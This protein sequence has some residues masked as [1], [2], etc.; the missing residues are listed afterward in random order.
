MEKES[1]DFKVHIQQNRLTYLPFDND[2]FTQNN[3]RFGRATA[4]DRPRGQNK[5]V[6]QTRP[7]TDNT[8]R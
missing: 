2:I 6:C 5:G 7:N 1:N 4:K 8:T 3:K